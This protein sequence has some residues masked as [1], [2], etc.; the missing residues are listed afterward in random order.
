MGKFLFSLQPVFLGLFLTDNEILPLLYATR[1]AGVLVYL[2]SLVN[3][4][5][6]PETL[7][8]NWLCW[9]GTALIE[10]LASS[11]QWWLSKVS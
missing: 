5:L 11:S 8:K 7:G 1:I 9:V 3:C 2:H 6:N 4:L 10:C